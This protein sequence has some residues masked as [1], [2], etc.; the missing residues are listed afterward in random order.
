MLSQQ[1]HQF[2][3]PKL[4]L[5][6]V[7]TDQQRLVQ[8]YLDPRIAILLFHRSTSKSLYA[9]QN[10]S[11]AP[12]GRRVPRPLAWTGPTAFDI[13]SPLCLSVF[14][15]IFPFLALPS[16]LRT[17][18]YRFVL[19]SEHNSVQPTQFKRAIRTA[20]N[21]NLAAPPTRNDRDS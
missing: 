16:K 5:R 20:L 15:L 10:L 17:N 11:L 3:A 9:L 7:W 1:Q 14:I 18:I 13:S 6:H 4:R 19:L 21:H 2:F 8:L 12:C